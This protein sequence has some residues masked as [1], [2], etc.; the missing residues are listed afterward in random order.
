[1]W[2][3]IAHRFW[4]AWINEMHDIMSKGWTWSLQQ[5]WL[6]TTTTYTLPLYA[7]ALPTPPIWKP[8]TDLCFVQVIWK[9]VDQI[10]PITVGSYVFDPDNSY[11]VSHNDQNT[12]DH[13]THRFGQDN[14]RWNLQVN[15]S[16]FYFIA[17]SMQKIGVLSN[18]WNVSTVLVQDMWHCLWTDP[19]CEHCPCRDLWMS[20][21]HKRRFC[22]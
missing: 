17:S 10:T 8:K 14:S 20:N 7:L 18:I 12:D 5:G 22:P 9:R 15:S 1:M 13:E 16:N 21:Q 6:E 11:S 19:K 4:L 2:L 3:D